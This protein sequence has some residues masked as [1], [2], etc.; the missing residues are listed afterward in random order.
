MEWGIKGRGEMGREIHLF[1]S[2]FCSINFFNRTYQV[3]I[4]AKG[5]GYPRG[6]ELLATIVS[7]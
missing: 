2:S 6:N 7:I 1:L 5:C 4:M 3:L